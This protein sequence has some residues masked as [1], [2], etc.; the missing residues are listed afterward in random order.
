MLSTMQAWFS[1]GPSSQPEKPASLLAEW[2]SYAAAQS[3]NS[4]SAAAAGGT[5]LEAGV[6]ESLAPLLK[7]ANETLLGA[8]SKVSQGVRELPGNVTTAASSVPSPKRLLYFSLMVA[9]GVFFMMLALTVGLSVFIIAPQKFALCFCLGCGFIMASFFVLKGPQAQI[10]HMT[11]KE[12]LASTVALIGS[13]GATLYVSLVLHSYVLAVV[14]CVAQVLALLYYVI[15]YFP[16]GS[17]GMKFI[18]G[19][20]MS[21][22]VGR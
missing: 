14:C 12:R 20:V 4:P 10:S 3:Q 1:G 11:S 21:K 9:T 15:S 13:M 7:S 16:G 22:V 19:M 8:F 6:P 18:S 17:S 5:D 2:N